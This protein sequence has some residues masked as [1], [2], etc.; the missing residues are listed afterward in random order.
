MLDV[1]HYFYEEDIFFTSIEQ[2]ES[3]DRARESIYRNF[4]NTTYPYSLNKTNTVKNFD[5]EEDEEDI[6]AFDPMQKQQP[7][8]PF[9]APTAVDASSEKPFGMALDEPFSH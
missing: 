5:I 2:A 1:L 3:R 9:V 6:T 7:T 8:K 4:Y